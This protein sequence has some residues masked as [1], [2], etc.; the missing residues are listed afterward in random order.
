MVQIRVFDVIGP[1]CVDPEDGTVLCTLTRN[2][3]SQGSAVKLDFDGVCTLTSSFLNSAVGCLRAT[4][5]AEVIR[6]N[7][8]W[9]GLDAEDRALLQLVL[10]NA[11]RFYDASQDGR[12]ALTSASLSAIED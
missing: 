5:S 7:L 3:L 11:N 1:I 2:A 6:D 8:F 10:N 9:D 4:F 12:D